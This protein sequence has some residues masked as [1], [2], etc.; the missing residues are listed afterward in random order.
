MD[1]DKAGDAAMA[2]YLLSQMLQM[3]ASQ[4]SQEA[5]HSPE[6]FT[7]RLR[8]LESAEHIKVPG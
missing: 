3:I 5:Y 1:V 7:S 8:L 6:L 4:A 2:G